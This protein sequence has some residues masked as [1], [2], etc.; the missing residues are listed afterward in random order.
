[1]QTALAF[2]AAFCI[3]IGVSAMAAAESWRDAS[4]SNTEPPPI[5]DGLC[6]PG[7]VGVW[8]DTSTVECLKELP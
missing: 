2:M 7:Q 3:A 5:P 8:I 4:P 1:M 6:K